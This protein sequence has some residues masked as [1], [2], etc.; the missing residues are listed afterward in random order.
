M[1]TERAEIL[2]QPDAHALNDSV[3]ARYRDW[4]A[5]E[6]Y[7]SFSDYGALHQWSITQTEAFWESLWRFTGVIASRGYTRVLADPGLPP[8]G[9]FEGARLNLAENLLR[10]A[11]RHPDSQEC[12]TEVSESRA[13]VRLGRGALLA[14]VGALQGWLRAQGVGVGDRVA[15]V[16]ANTHEALVAM[17]A[18]TGLGAI[19]SSAS[20]DFGTAAILD[21]FG[22]I[23]PKVL[24]AVTGYRYQG[25]DHDRGAQNRA[26]AAALPGLERVLSIALLPGSAHPDDPVF[27]PWEQALAA[28]VGALPEFVQLP[29]DHP[30]YIL[31]SSGTTG[32]PKCIVHGAAGMLLNHS[33]E[34]LLHAD[35]GPGDSLCYFTTTGWMMWNWMASA[36]LTGARLV[37]YDGSPAQPSLERL[38]ALL[39]QER[40]SHFGTSAKYLGNCRKQGL[41]PGVDHD[42]AAL[43]VLFSTGSPLLAE[44]YDWVYE[45]LGRGLM[46]SSISGGTDICGCFVGG[47]PLVAVRRGEIPCRLL[48]VD[49]R[50]FD[51][52]GHDTEGARGELVCLG[53]LPCMPVGFWDD[54][55]GSRYRDAY[56]SR[57]PGVWAHGDFVEFT[58]HGGAI[59]HGRAD[60]TLN[61][62]GV[63]IGTAELYRQVETLPEIADSL[64]VGAPLPDGDVEVLL[65][66]VMAEG[67]ALDAAMIQTIRQRIRANAS[68]RHVPARI[69]AV[70]QVPY[71]R[72]GKKVELAVA[73]MLRGETGGDNAHALAN[74]EALAEIAAALAVPTSRRRDTP[75][76]A[77]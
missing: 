49:V 31:Y 19:W 60:A 9:W 65:L 69:L 3:M 68:P 76:A 27:V 38:W 67:H 36:L 71:T 39:A 64:V 54:A 7:G 16:V 34:L 8:R 12:V 14:Q 30:V 51:P 22:Q 6:G 50:A 33:K 13:T 2:W 35:L 23:R 15:G 1:T 53:P 59:I 25:R 75:V 43:R 28:H 42:L 32:V 74:P 29:P 52:E 56:F 24:L 47:S 21:R 66:V 4:L 40:V 18:T 45:A 48:G 72:S 17:L 20:P 37:L 55:D 5:R 10:H 57:F 73:R 63:R 46:L 26:L 70:S 58:A 62:G 41:T 77:L 11:L 44:D 61:P